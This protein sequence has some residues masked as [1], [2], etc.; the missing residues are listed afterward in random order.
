[1][2]RPAHSESLLA[3]VLDD[4]VAGWRSRA[5]SVAVV[6][7]YAAIGWK[8]GNSV[9]V[10][11]PCALPLLCIWFPD[12]LGQHV[13]GRITKPSPAWLV[14]VFGWVVLLVPVMQVGIIWLRTS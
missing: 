1:M 3:I 12:T 5:A 4:E 2:Q 14:W 6:L 13:G 8:Y 7:I 10:I 9:R 11:A